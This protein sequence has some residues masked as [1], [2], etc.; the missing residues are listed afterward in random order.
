MAQTSIEGLYPLLIL[1]AGALIRTL[2]KRAKEQKERKEREGYASPLPPSPPIMMREVSPPPE[3]P[4]ETI[5]SSQIEEVIPV[6]EKKKKPRIA[7]LISGLKHKQDLVLLSEI[8]VNKHSI[9]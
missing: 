1:A 7:K 4:I 2:K 5:A 9:K 8:L 6:G 3:I